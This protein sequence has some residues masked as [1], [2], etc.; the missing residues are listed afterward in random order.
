MSRASA[1]AWRKELWAVEFT[2]SIKDDSPMLLGRGWYAAEPIFYPGEPSRALLFTTRTEA[3]KWCRSQLLKY[4][5]RTDCCADWRFRPVR[6]VETV[7]V[8]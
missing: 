4:A 1:S 7:K 2:E 8:L 5:G 3:R 6:V